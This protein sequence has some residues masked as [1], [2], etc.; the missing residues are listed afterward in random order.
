[1]Y[2]KGS[3]EEDILEAEQEAKRAEA[4]YQ[5]LRAG[6][7]PEDIAAAEARVGEVRGK[8]RELEVNIAEAVVK[9]PE[10][11]VIEVMGVRKGDL[12]RPNQPIV[13]V[14]RA[15]DLWV[16]VYVPET[17]MGKIRLGQSVEVTIDSYPGKRFVGKVIQVSSRS[18]FTP[19]N[20]QSPDERRH[21]VFGVK[22]RVDNPQGVFKAGMA[23]EVILPLH[24]AP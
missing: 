16:R 10:R 9:A 20:V 17:E 23:A 24:P 1:M 3:R 21:Q 5:L 7:R 11:A 18:E 2:K 19:R 13:T 4:Q 22:V 12:V 8:L 14:L 6:T 15:E